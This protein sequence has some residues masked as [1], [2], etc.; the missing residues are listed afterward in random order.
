MRI[1]AGCTPAE[2]ARPRSCTYIRDRS[3]ALGLQRERWAQ[4]RAKTAIWLRPAHSG[5]LIAR[6]RD[7]ITLAHQAAEDRFPGDTRR[8]ARHDIWCVQRGAQIQGAVR[9]TGAVMR[10]VLAEYA[11]EVA[12]P[13]QQ[14]EP[15]RRAAVDRGLPC[16]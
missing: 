9:A 8:G 1:P 2:L 7:R 14:H 13:E 6:S 11:L 5:S 15:R 10:D 4:W 16:R 12:V 3:L